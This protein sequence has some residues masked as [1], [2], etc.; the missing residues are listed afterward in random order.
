MPV[1]GDLNNMVLVKDHD[2]FANALVFKV[3]VCL[4]R[5]IYS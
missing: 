1:L 4:E 5:T 2:Q 3:D